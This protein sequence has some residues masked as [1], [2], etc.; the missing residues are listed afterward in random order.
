MAG[1]CSS[2][3]VGVSGFLASTLSAGLELVAS[4][5]HVVKA[6]CQEPEL[7]KSKKDGLEAMKLWRKTYEA[8]GWFCYST[9]KGSAVIARP[10]GWN[11]DPIPSIRHA[12]TLREVVHQQET[13]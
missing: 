12:I 9:D 4:K 10:P 7:V 13:S 2:A 3:G 11:S 8:A 1:L 6:T 5:P